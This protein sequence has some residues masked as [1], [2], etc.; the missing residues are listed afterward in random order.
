MARLQRGAAATIH[1]AADRLDHVIERAEVK[2]TPGLAL[3]DFGAEH[4]AESAD[5]FLQVSG[6]MTRARTCRFIEV[7]LRL[8]KVTVCTR[9][10]RTDGPRH[11]SSGL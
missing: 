1:A 5:N 3:F 10:F 7:L 11:N 4:V 6:L 2:F 8:I 9:P